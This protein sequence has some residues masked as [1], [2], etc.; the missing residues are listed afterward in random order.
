VDR[1]TCTSSLHKHHIINS[2]I[3]TSACVRSSL[4]VDRY[5]TDLVGLKL[6]MTRRGP[7]LTPAYLSMLPRS[8]SGSR[9]WWAEADL[10]KSYIA[11]I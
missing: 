8:L 5:N 9:I 3:K 11:E 10:P 2:H 7:I 1:A 4:I 6:R